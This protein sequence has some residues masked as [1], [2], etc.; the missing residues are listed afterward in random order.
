MPDFVTSMELRVQADQ[1]KAALKATSAEVQGLGQ[2]AVTSSAKAGGLAPAVAG[3]ARATPAVKA[4][5]AQITGIGTASEVAAGRMRQI[6]GAS[7]LAAGSV[8]NLT[9]QFND[10]GM[11]MAAGQNPLMLAIQQGTQVSQVIGPM[12]AAG[13]VKA[14]KAAFIGMIN[15]VSLATLGIIGGGAA[16]VQW[17]VRAARAGGDT[18]SLEDRVKDLTE[19]TK[20]YEE[21][22][23]AAAVPIEELRA[24]YGDL[25]DEIQRV[26]ELELQRTLDAA[27]AA[28]N[29]AAKAAGFG[30]DVPSLDLRNLASAQATIDAMRSKIATTQAALTASSAPFFDFTEGYAE[31]DRAIAALDSLKHKVQEVA[32]TYG[33]TFEQARKLAEAQAVL[34]EAKG[35]QAQ[36]EAGTTLLNVMVQVFGSMQAA[37]DATDGLAT[38]LAAAVEAGGNIAAVTADLPGHL[39]EAKDVAGALWD[40]LSAALGAATD[41]GNADLSSG[42]ETAVGAA[43]RLFAKLGPV[44]DRMRQMAQDRADWA[45]WTDPGRIL[46]AGDDERGSQLGYVQDAQDYRYR[47]SIR[48]RFGVSGAGSSSGAARDS[49]A[50]L[51]AEAQ[52][53]LAALDVAIAAINEKV[54]LGLMTTAEGTDAIA[55]AKR[56]AAGAIAALIPQVEKVAPTAKT[57]IEQMRAMAGELVRDV[58]AAG[59]SLAQTMADGFKGPFA[60]FLA[61]TKSAKDAFGDFA[62]FVQQKLATMFADRFTNAF[63]TPLFDSLLGAFGMANGGVIGAHGVDAAYAGGGVPGLSA[64]RNSVVDRPTPFALPGG[65]TGLMGEAGPEAIIPLAR[66]AGGKLGVRAT[67]ALGEILLPLARAAGGALGVEV[68]EWH[69]KLI[70]RAPIAPVAPVAFA[71]GGVVDG[72]GGLVGEAGGILAAGRAGATATRVVVN[73]ANNGPPLQAQQT[74]ERMEGNTRII[75]MVLDQVDAHLAANARRGVGALTNAFADSYGVGRAVR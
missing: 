1:A 44:L 24:K 30:F 39:A 29:A 65:K 50:S 54:S 72:G 70:D 57:A 6:G 21:A 56:R 71:Q 32:D 58:G 3:V 23:K 55:D 31:V 2:A 14:L 63:I 8:G 5:Q 37:N 20:A 28:A 35:A 33:L 17:A 49:L 7:T 4:L 68:P 18:K 38:K 10:I 59:S 11:M 73:I 51:Q 27:Q 74:G 22:A 34:S 53:A 15:P 67:G 25:A 52:A 46:R 69:S 45:A 40:A 16:L 42:I 64:H 61:G 36:V 62:S 75:E 43:G 12:G 48:N 9:A 26:R 60:A 66:G 41:I 19:A 47:E 13:A